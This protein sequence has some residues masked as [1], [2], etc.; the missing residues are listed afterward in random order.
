MGMFLLLSGDYRVGADGPYKIIA[1]E[2]AMGLTMPWTAIEICR[3]RLTPAH[4]HRAVSLA[5]LYTPEA[6]VDAGILDRAVPPTELVGA[7]RET[8]ATLVSLDRRAHA[9]TK[10]RVRNDALGAI[11]TAIEVDDK[12]FRVL[13]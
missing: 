2:V 5:E 3:Q 11:R 6:A 13:R 12:A 7:A 4:F 9:A 1:N 10:L 8:A